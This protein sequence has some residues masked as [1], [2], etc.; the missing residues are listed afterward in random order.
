[1]LDVLDGLLENVFTILPYFIIVVAGLL[2]CALFLFASVGLLV[3]KGE[4]FQKI[5]AVGLSVI[6]VCCCYWFFIYLGDMGESQEGF[7]HVGPCLAFLIAAIVWFIP[8][9][10]K[11]CCI[12]FFLSGIVYLGI[13][14]FG[15]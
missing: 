5:E 9:I 12:P 11:S 14:I 13:A 4:T 7:A 10:L 15:V 3:E 8:H 1:M 2:S 6:T